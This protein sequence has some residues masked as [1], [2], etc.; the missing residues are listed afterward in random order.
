MEWRCD[1]FMTNE[2]ITAMPVKKK[3]IHLTATLSLTLRL[4]ERAW[5]LTGSRSLSTSLVQQILE[6]S[7]DGVVFETENTIYHLTYARRPA[8]IEVMC[9]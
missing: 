2:K 4:H 9:A 8:E 7:Q 5:I 1:S 3:Q 6:V